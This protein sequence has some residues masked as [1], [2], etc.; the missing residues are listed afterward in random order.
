METERVDEAS[1]E[2]RFQTK[3][4]LKLTIEKGAY[5]RGA[6]DIY[7]IFIVCLALIDL[8]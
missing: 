4:L 3:T 6:L 2:K 1:T 7:F 8:S 5:C